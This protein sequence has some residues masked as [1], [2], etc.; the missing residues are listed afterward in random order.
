MK[1][2]DHLLLC[3][4]TFR[5][6]GPKSKDRESDRRENNKHMCSCMFIPSWFVERRALLRIV[7]RVLIGGDSPHLANCTMEVNPPPSFTNT[8]P[9]V[10][11]PSAAQW[12]HQSFTHTNTHWH[13]MNPLPPQPQKVILTFYIKITSSQN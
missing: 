9:H 12:S 5:T 11:S 3:S 13:S 7:M 1:F 10:A 4:L 8:A 2:S 6:S